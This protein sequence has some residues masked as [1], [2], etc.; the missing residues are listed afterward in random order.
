MLAIFM[1]RSDFIHTP[2]A[3]HPSLWLASQLA[4][5]STRCVD[6]GYPALSQQLPGGGCWLLTKPVALLLR[7][8]RPFYGSPLTLV[9]AP[10][11]IEA[12]W[13]GEAQT[14]DYFIAEGHD[15][16]HYWLYRE[17]PSGATGDT[18]RWYLHGL[19]A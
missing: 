9:S 5:A 18:P 4:H 8:H 12:G 15:H 7:D 10:E 16:A 2:E 13:W 6:T 1:L 14:R 11:R 17:R 19:F 3:P